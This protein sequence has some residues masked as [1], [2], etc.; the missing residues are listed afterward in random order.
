MSEEINNE[1]SEEQVDSL[2]E[3]RTMPSANIP[4]KA[5]SPESATPREFE[6]T[7]DGRV[8]KADLDKVK[9][10]AQ[11]GYGAPKRIGELNSKLSQM[12]EQL[13]QYK[14]TAQKYGSVEEYI[15]TNPQ[16][17]DHVQQQWEQRQQFTT[18][19][20][21]PISKEL[22]TVKQELSD[23]RSFKEQLLSKEQQAQVQ[24][25]DAQLNE[26]IQSIQKQYGDLDWKGIDENGRSL[27]YRVLE[28]ANKNNIQSFKTAFRDYMHDHI[29]Q[30]A[31]TKAKQAAADEIQK[32]KKLGLLGKSQAPIKGLKGPRGD[33]KQSTYED[34]MREALEEMRN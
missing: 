29:V 30:L 23:L 18:N 22:S 8:V 4:D 20:D 33:I 10:W 7:V 3:Q 31:Q 25:E 24:K 16:W 5:P 1:I 2:L 6:L 32:S 11:M 19:P 34:L 15:K 17:W 28:H 13:N 14:T 21:D 9:Q 26:D 12:E 27:E